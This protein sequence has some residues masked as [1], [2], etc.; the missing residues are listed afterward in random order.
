[1]Y[2]QKIMPRNHAYI[3]TCTKTIKLI[4]ATEVHK[5]QV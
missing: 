4:V 1:M 3:E 2:T 5:D